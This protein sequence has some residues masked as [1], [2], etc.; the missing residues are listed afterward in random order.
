MQK[1]DLVYAGHMLDLAR[2]AAGKVVGKTRA[3]YDQDENLRLALAHLIQTLGEAARRVSPAFQQAHPEIPWK[4]IVGMRHKVVHDYLHVDFDIVWA[5]VTADLP[6]LIA[7][8]E[9][10]VPPPAP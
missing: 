7:D 2:K 6:P 10:V 5:V 3:E 1:D 9:K 8:L 4:G